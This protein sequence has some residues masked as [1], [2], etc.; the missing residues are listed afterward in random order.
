MLAGNTTREVE[1]D[2]VAE[3]ELKTVKRDFEGLN[4]GIWSK[5]SLGHRTKFDELC[6]LDRSGG[7]STGLMRKYASWFSMCAKMDQLEQLV[8]KDGSDGEK[9]KF[10]GG[11]VY[12]LDGSWISNGDQELRCISDAFQ[13]MLISCCANVNDQRSR[14]EEESGISDDDVNIS[15]G[16]SVISN[17]DVSFINRQQAAISDDDISS[18]VRIE[19]FDY[20]SKNAR[21]NAGQRYCSLRLVE[22]ELDSYCSLQLV[23]FWNSVVALVVVAAGS[24]HAIARI[25]EEMT[26]GVYCCARGIQ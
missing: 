19:K 5:S 6:S 9:I 10:T 18:D 14:C 3:Q 2:T 1:L 20:R 26:R 7:R 12:H 4:E 25:N 17:Y 8:R 23:E 11:L 21:V 13:T 24:R 22:F 15:I 16:G